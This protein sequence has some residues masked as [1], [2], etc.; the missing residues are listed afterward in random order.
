M[1]M[2]IRYELPE[3]QAYGANIFT[4]DA[5]KAAKNKAHKV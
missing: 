4:K 5:L 3:P 2:V 1:Q